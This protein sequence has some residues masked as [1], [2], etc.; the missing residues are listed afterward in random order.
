MLEALKEKVFR[1]NIRL[2]EAGLVILTWGNAS[3]IDRSKGLVVIK[4]SGVGYG[5]LSPEKMVVVD[6]NGNVLEGKLRPSSDTP[7]HIVLY[8]NFEGVN[9]IVHTHSTWATAWAQ[10]KLPI[11]SLGTTHADHFHN[12]IPCTRFLSEEET[13]ENYEMNTGRAIVETFARRD[14]LSTPGVLVA[15]HAPFTWGKSVDDAVNNSIVLEEVAKMAFLTKML[16]SD[17]ET[18]PVYIIDKHYSR[19]HGKNAYYGQKETLGND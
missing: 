8:R 3:G 15:G 7:T 19:K 10:S 4:P 6:L 9:G 18:L 2:V 12:E 13:E 1:A 5:E 17:V 16:K 14:Y 11:P